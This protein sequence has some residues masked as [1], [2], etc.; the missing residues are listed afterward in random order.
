M[1]VRWHSR[2]TTLRS[3]SIRGLAFVRQTTTNLARSILPPVQ[4]SD[5]DPTQAWLAERQT[6]LEFHREKEREQ[7]EQSRLPADESV[8][9]PCVWVAEVYFA[10]HVPSLIRSLDSLGWAAEDFTS[11]Y[12]LSAWIERGRRR[13]R[14]AGFHTGPWISSKK[15]SLGMLHGHLADL[16]DGVRSMNFKVFQPAPSYI[17]I[18]SLFMLEEAVGEQVTAALRSDYEVELESLG[19]AWSIIEP[20]EQRAIA[21][22]RVR[23]ELMRRCSA[24]VGQ[25]FPGFFARMDLED[26]PFPTAEL[27]LLQST[28]LIASEERPRKGFLDSLGFGSSFLDF[29]GT[30]HQGL[31]LRLPPD[32]GAGE[33]GLT[34]AASMHELLPGDALD[35]GYGGRTPQGFVQRLHGLSEFI[36]LWAVSVLIRDLDAVV[37]DTRDRMG[38]AAGRVDTGQSERIEELQRGVEVL[39]ADFI[40]GLEEWRSNAGLSYLLDE[41]ADFRPREGRRGGTDSLTNSIGEGIQE[42]AA[43]IL[44]AVPILRDALQIQS[45]LV[46][47]QVSARVVQTNFLLQVVTIVVAFL[48]LIVAIALR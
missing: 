20:G 42:D 36:G 1:G 27:L 28:P 47:S 45:S 33:R 13:G 46:A 10:S 48:A 17:V 15:T 19:T 31:L 25:H 24:Y 5:V 9:M 3:A 37:A 43:R 35:N 16:P 14:G 41:A 44:K 12:D 22:N 38:I 40:F 23:S 6:S 32:F 18:V 8:A 7:N 26:D 30:S 21:V 34:F 39:V 2:W 29:V 4:P 11:S